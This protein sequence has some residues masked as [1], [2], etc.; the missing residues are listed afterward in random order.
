MRMPNTVPS[1]HRPQYCRGVGWGDAP[2][3]VVASLASYR[4]QVKL[5][6]RASTIDDSEMAPHE[7][8]LDMPVDVMVD[9]QKGRVSSGIR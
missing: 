4:G 3:R 9:H 8:Q 7:V 5:S 6:R 2:R 1:D